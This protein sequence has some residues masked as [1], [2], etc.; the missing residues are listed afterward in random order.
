MKRIILLSLLL[1]SAV[2]L[3]APLEGLKKIYLVST[4]GELTQVATV[5]FKPNNDNIDYTV[6]MID[7]PFENQFLSMRPFKCVMGSKQVMCHVPYPY[8]KKGFIKRSDLRDLSFDLLFLHKSPSEYGINM[9]N[10][11]FYKLSVVG[12]QIEGIVSEVD[13]NILASPP[14][15][16]DEPFAEDE[17]FEA[18]ENN[19]VYPRVLIK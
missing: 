17:I 19:Y 12:I 6:S 5:E 14:D 3:A 2:S 16:L 1:T 10:G 15:S 13:M 7:K 18:D 4:T 11:I 8:E 9:W